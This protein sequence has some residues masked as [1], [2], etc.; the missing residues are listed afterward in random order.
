MARVSLALCQ[1]EGSQVEA[2]FESLCFPC[3]PHWNLR[4]QS[5]QQKLHLKSQ[6]R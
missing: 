3:V 5:T 4:V 2:Q 1:Q 6:N